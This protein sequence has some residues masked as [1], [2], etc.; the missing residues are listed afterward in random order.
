VASSPPSA[1]RSAPGLPDLLA[2]GAISG[3][4]IGI[5]V[6]AGYLLDRATGTSPLLTFLGLAL[7]ILGAGIGARAVIRPYLR[8]SASAAARPSEINADTTDTVTKTKD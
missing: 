7:G 3:V 8:A 1:K 4:S 5:G 2:I 6:F